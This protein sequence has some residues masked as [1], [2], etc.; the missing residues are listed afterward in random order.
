MEY[1]HPLHTQSLQAS[2]QGFAYGNPDASEIGGWQPYLGTDNCIFGLELLKNTA[3]IPLGLAV[4][5]LD[6]GIEVN[7]AGFHCPR[8]GAFLIDRVA[9]DHQSAHCTA[10]EAQQ[11]NLHSTATE[12]SHFH[13]H[14]LSQ[15]DQRTQW[16]GGSCNPIQMQ[17]TNPSG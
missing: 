12:C 5:I 1:I 15:Q 3:E 16:V 17:N 14:C 9:T 11:R 4:P 2:L 6:G 7:H 8:N 13:R 10:A